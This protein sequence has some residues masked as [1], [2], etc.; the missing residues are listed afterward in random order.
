MV[1]FNKSQLFVSVIFVTTLFLVLQLVFMNILKNIGNKNDKNSLEFEDNRLV[2]K[3]AVTDN[4]NDQRRF[5]PRFNF[6]IDQMNNFITTTKHSDRNLYQTSELKHDQNPQVQIEK[7]ATTRMLYRNVSKTEYYIPLDVN[8]QPFLRDALPF[9]NNK[10]SYNFSLISVIRTEKIDNSGKEEKPSDFLAIE[11]ENRQINSNRLSRNAKLGGRKVEDYYRSIR[12]INKEKYELYKPDSNG[13]FKC[14]NSNQKIPYTSLNDEYCD[15][16]DGTDE[17]GTAACQFSMFYCSTQNE[18]LLDN[19][20]PSSRVDDKICDCCD[21]SDETEIK[22]KNTCE[23]KMSLVKSQVSIGQQAIIEKRK[24]LA[25]G[26]FQNERVYGPKGV[27]YKLSEKCFKIDRSEYT[28]E[29]CPYKKTVQYKNTNHNSQTNI[30]DKPSLVQSEKRKW[31][32]KMDGGDPHLCSTPRHSEIH[33][34]CGI[35][36]KLM[37]VDEPDKCFYLFHLTTPAAC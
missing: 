25:E 29:V 16:I 4:Q 36:D 6:K 12:G 2:D 21:G 23:E 24:Y 18:F 22:C 14:L 3:R 31:I 27:F 33:F 28:F 32:L 20:I 17:P 11:Q 26:E 1:R 34:E 5:N 30:G 10:N 15:C 9:F 7:Q 35:E 37:S 13:L 8:R 19:Y